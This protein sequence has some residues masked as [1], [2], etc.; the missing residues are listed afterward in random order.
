MYRFMPA[1]T[2]DRSPADSAIRDLATPVLEIEENML[3]VPLIGTIDAR[4]ADRMTDQLL[5]AVGRSRAR[6]VVMDTTGVSRIDGPGAERLLGTVHATRLLGAVVILTGI[7]D[8]VAG[9]IVSSG[10]TLDELTCATDLRSGIELGRRFLLRRRTPI[11]GMRDRA[12]ARAR[13]PGEASVASATHRRSGRPLHTIP[14]P[15][16]RMAV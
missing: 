10:A 5:R 11:A 4:R 12:A 7:F 3:L 9:A 6:V 2:F 13:R 1:A 14:G 16:L 15:E 8:R